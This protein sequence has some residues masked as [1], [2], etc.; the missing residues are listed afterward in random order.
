MATKFI[1]DTD[2]GID[3][4]L[5]IACAFADPQIEVLALTSVF[6]NASVTQTT[7]NALRILEVLE[8]DVPVYPGAHRPLTMPAKDFPAFVHG[9]NGLGNIP[10]PK[11]KRQP[12]PISAAQYI[13]NAANQYPGEITIVALGP[14]TNLAL[15][16]AL[17]PTVAQKIKRVVSMGGNLHVP[18]NVSAAAEAN[19]YCDPD[20]ADQ[21]YNAGWPVS[22]VG[23]DVT[24]QVTTT[25]EYFEQLEKKQP[26]VGKFLH[27]ITR[28]YMDFYQDC[29]QIDGCH[30]HDSSAIA[31]ATHPEWFGME[32]GQL[33]VVC[34]GECKGKLLLHKDAGY[35]HKFNP[36]LE[37]PEVDVAVTVDVKAIS[38]WLDTIF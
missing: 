30:I 19:I 22:V 1:I 27:Q 9:E 38:N 31:C 29:Y 15:A 20:S 4:A 6:G 24:H 8:Q 14:L 33:R 13:V 35:I 7:E 37:K 25:I 23:L 10:Q 2:P 18:G 5:A 34:D 12:E 17:D 16:V 32:S 36:W 3:D 28:F 26:I 21:V 11:A